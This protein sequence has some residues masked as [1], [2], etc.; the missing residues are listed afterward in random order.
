MSIKGKFSGG[1]IMDETGSLNETP[2]FILSKLKEH[3]KE[4]INSRNQNGIK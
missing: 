1:K 3:L 4:V 2:Q